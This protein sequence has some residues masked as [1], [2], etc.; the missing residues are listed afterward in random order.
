MQS[1][2]I[3][4][5]PLRVGVACNIKVD[6]GSDA[7]AEFDEPE[8]VDAICAA[9][10]AG[11]FS[12]SVIEASEGFPRKLEAEN[13]DIV[14]N[15]AE[16]VSGRSR[17]AH[18]PAILEYCGVPYTGS[19]AAAL[20]IA[21]DKAMTKRLV[22]SCGIDTPAYDVI[23]KTAP[24]Q[25]A[26]LPYPVLVKPNA[27]GSSKGVSD[28]SVAANPAELRELAGQAM[29]GCDGDVLAEQYIDGR[30][31][32]VGILG[33]GP[34]LRIFEPMEV[35]FNKKRG[36]YKVYS[37]EIKRNYR[38]FITYRC[39]PDLPDDLIARMKRDAQIIYET[40]GCRDFARVDY[41]L[42]DEGKLY[43]IEINP[44]SGLAPDYSDYIIAAKFHNISYNDIV[45]DILHCALKRYG[46]AE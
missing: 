1:N 46:M 6:R 29:K 27:E 7:Q 8:T 25:P 21:L 30:E 31:F 32:T 43:F 33:N 45:C 44:L 11:G 41:R 35:I 12:P 10:A 38:E 28:I 17:E 36:A 13:P 39:P 4:N 40:I 34:D 14:F 5:T 3:C 24:E 19:D 2:G 23:K 16:G 9:L 20:A 15:I 26:D 42:S 37:Y 22:N 18:I